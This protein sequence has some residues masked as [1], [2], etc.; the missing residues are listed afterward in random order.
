M[1]VDEVADFLIREGVRPRFFA[2]NTVVAD[3]AVVLYQ[4]GPARWVVFY[5][6]RGVR[7]SERV[8]DSEDAACQALI[9]KALNMEKWMREHESR[10]RRPYPVTPK[11]KPV[12]KD[13]D[14][15][16]DST[17]SITPAR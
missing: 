7:S 14:F 8:Y 6:E 5:T 9:K 13:P 11:P 10:P 3:D 1:K 17:G 2:I 12:K 4:E 15:I 16:V